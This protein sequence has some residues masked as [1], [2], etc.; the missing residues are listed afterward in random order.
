M[1]KRITYQHIV[2]KIETIN[3]EAG[4]TVVRKYDESNIWTI[5]VYKDFQDPQ[6]YP[7]FSF[8][9]DIGDALAFLGGILASVRYLR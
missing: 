2:E 3:N 9:G 8:V 6:Q 4:R 5:Y 7:D 1:S